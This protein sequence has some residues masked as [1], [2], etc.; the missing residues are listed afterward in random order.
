M[1]TQEEST[2]NWNFWKHKREV[3][4]LEAAFLA[5]NVNPDTQDY[6]DIRSFGLD[7]NVNDLLRLLK[8]NRCLRQF[9]TPGTIDIGD[10]NFSGVYLPEFAAWCLQIGYEIPL[11]LAALAKSAPM[12]EQQAEL[13]GNDGGCIDTVGKPK[14]KELTAW[15]RATWNNENRPGGTA[16]FMKLK[17]YVNTNGSPILEY[18]YAGK[19]AGIK[20][21]TS[22]GTTGTMVKKTILTKVSAFK[23]TSHSKPL[24]IAQNRK[25]S[26]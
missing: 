13:V 10:S 3:G 11:D 18:Y 22:T 25:N 12:T 17:K 24:S 19:N 8:D 21:R 16:F 26:L 15:L 23:K 5:C 7:K 6:R 14:E 20:W 2:I 1:V 9:F 4:L